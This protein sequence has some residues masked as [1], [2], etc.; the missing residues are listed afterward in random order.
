MAGSKFSEGI[1]L[2]QKHKSVCEGSKDIIAKVV[3]LYTNRALA[4]SSLGNQDDCLKDA[5][6]V[7]ENLDGENSK[8]LFR[9]AMAYKSKGQLAKASIDL[10]AL[11]KVEPKNPHAKKEL[12]AIKSELKNAPKIQEVGVTP[13]NKVEEVQ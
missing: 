10:E 3:Q 13:S 11:V 12:I 1:N 6:Y 9:R 2:Y 7:L 8:A 4:W 5:S